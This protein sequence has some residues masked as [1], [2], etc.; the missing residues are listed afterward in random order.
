[1][2]QVLIIDDDES[3]RGLLRGTLEREGY[4]VTEAR[5]GDE[6]IRVFRE[7]P[8]DVILVDMIMPHKPGWETIL[9]LKRE[10]P[11]LKAIGISAGGNQGP[12]G[13]LRLA[14]RFGAKR[15]LAKPIRKKVLLDCIKE[16]LVGRAER[17]RVEMRRIP[18]AQVK[19]SVLVVDMDEQHSWTLCD[20]L[21]R[22]GHSVTDTPRPAYAIDIISQRGF[23]VA[24]LDVTS[25]KVGDTD[26]I[27]LLR[28]DWTHP[29]I[30]AMAD[31][32]AL[33]VKKSV[34]SRGANYFM[35]KPVDLFELLDL[36]CPP[37]AFSSQ[38]DG[39]DVLE[40]LQF[41]L[42]TGRQTVVKVRSREGKTCKLYC[43]E[44]DII[45]AEGESDFG[46]KAFFRC[47]AFQGGSLRNLA[48]EEPINKTIEVPGDFLLLEAA[49]RRDESQL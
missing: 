43:R 48:W 18:R 12:F 33:V 49:R 13:Y 3:I 22:A 20:G 25:T 34:I 47:M 7:S 39:F 8:A 28:S 44:G 30:I 38:L 37:P 42:L 4:K 9:E 24:I 1:M 19:K 41:I 36:I 32:D 2:T 11:D 21:T 10:F 16:V 29:L 45:H 31:F 6:G 15:I 27:E 17:Q 23:E 35:S 40:Y 26:L 46:E 5:D 14:K